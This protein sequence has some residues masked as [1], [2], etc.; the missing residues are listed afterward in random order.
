MFQKPIAKIKNSIFPVFLYKVQSDIATWEAA[1]T[2]FFINDKGFFLTSHHVIKLNPDTAYKPVFVGNTPYNTTGKPVE[3]AE[4]F[5]DPVRDIFLGRV[6]SDFLAPVQLSFETQYEGKSVVACGYP[7][8][9]L[10]FNE[11]HSLE[12]SQ[13]RQYWQPTFIIDQFDANNNDTA[14]GSVII[15][16]DPAINGMSGGP[17]FDLDGHVMGMSVANYHRKVPGSDIRIDNGVAIKISAIVDV[18]SMCK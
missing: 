17:L 11:D 7:L 14:Y 4:I 15:T 18:L 1:G 2:G 6:E 10:K 5:S 8:P 9:E 13:V 16:R 3:I 12:L